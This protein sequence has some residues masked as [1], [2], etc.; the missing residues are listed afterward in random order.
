MPRA[1]QEWI[2]KDDNAPIP[3]R[4]KLRVRSR[5]DQCCQNCGI[6]VRYG[7]EIDHVVALV[8]WIATAQAQHGNRESNLRFLCKAC[9]GAKTKADVVIKSRAAKT[10]KRMAGFDKPRRGFWAWR[11]FDGTIVYKTARDA[12]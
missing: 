9:H 11:K 4:V 3:P 7:G 1:T 12:E 5:A 10:Q 8:N 6:R 2:G